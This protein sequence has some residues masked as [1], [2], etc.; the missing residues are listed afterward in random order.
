[1]PIASA[2]ARSGCPVCIMAETPI[3]AQAPNN[4]MRATVNASHTSRKARRLEPVPAPEDFLIM[5]C[6]PNHRFRDRHPEPAVACDS[7]PASRKYQG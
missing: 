7:F 1:M 5:P 6:P 2:A 4:A 3:A